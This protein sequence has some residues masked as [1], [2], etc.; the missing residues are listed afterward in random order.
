MKKIIIALFFTVSFSPAKTQIIALGA[1]PTCMTGGDSWTGGFGGQ[2]SLEPKIYGNEKGGATV[3]IGVTQQGSNYKDD[4]FEGETYKGKFKMNYLI[5]PLL[6]QLYFARGF[7]AELGLQ[8]MVL[9]SAKDKYTIGNET[10]TDNIKRYLKSFNLAI[11]AGGGYRWKNG[12]GAGVRVQYGLLDI[13]K[14]SGGD[15]SRTILYAILLSYQ[16]RSLNLSAKKK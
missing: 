12:F 8:P 13:Y 4:Y 7:Y 2:L 9:L 10:T 15:A 3:G 6:Y 16:I 5:F 14:E 11:P 1:G